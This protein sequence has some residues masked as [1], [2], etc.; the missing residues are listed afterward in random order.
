MCIEK[1]WRLGNMKISIDMKFRPKREKRI[2]RWRIYQ[3][4]KNILD[5]EVETFRKAFRIN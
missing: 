2:M 1:S 5:G 3:D 4:M